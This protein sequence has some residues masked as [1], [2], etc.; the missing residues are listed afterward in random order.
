MSHFETS[1]NINFCL[2]SLIGFD[3]DDKSN[4]D[5]ANLCNYP[6]EIVGIEDK[7]LAN[8]FVDSVDITKISTVS[9]QKYNDLTIYSTYESSI[10]FHGDSG[11]E[12]LEN[13][14]CEEDI[15]SIQYNLADNF[16]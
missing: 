15:I 6:V 16:D 5:E 10:S 4:S 7:E 14:P 3:F 2:S 13:I 1:H 12:T 8:V 9:M 11:D